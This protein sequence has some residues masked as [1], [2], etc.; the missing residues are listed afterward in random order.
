M[1][2]QLGRWSFAEILYCGSCTSLNPA[3]TANF[4]ASMG[5]DEKDAISVVDSISTVAVGGACWSAVA[6]SSSAGGGACCCCFLRPKPPNPKP[7]NLLAIAAEA[8]CCATSPAV[9][10][11]G[12]GPLGGS[13]ASLAAGRGSPFAV[14]PRRPVSGPLRS[15][16][17]R[18][19][20]AWEQRQ[21]MRKLVHGLPGKLPL[22]RPETPPRNNRPSLAGP[23]P[24]SVPSA[25]L[26]QSPP[27]L[28]RSPPAPRP[29]HVSGGM[30]ISRLC[31]SADRT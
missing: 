8:D 18:R 4:A 20:C 19:G 6:E 3:G 13:G 14:A 29:A 12:S 7:P 11:C 17:C 9:G 16:C 15:S 2:R 24:G 23:S 22:S 27:A 25:P 28:R 10:I 1:P 5:A 26:R 21:S 31:N 30:N